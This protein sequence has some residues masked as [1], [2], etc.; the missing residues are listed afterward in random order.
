MRKTLLLTAAAFAVA[1][2]PAAAR[3]GSGY[4]GIEGGLLFPKDQDAD[5]DVDFTTTQTPATPAGP[6]GP[7]D[8]NFE[9]SFGLDYKRGLDIDA[10]AGFDFGAFR[11]E[12]ELGY[13]RSKLDEFEFDDGDIAAIN[14]ALN[15]PSGTGDPGAPGLPAISDT[16]FDLG[17]RV[18]VL[19]G[20][21]NALADFGDENGVSFYAGGG[22]GRA[23]VKAFGD[24]DAAWAFQAIA[25][26]RYAISPGIDFGLKYRYFR[27]GNVN[28]TDDSFALAGNPNAVT[29]ATGAGPVIVNQTSN[30]VAFADFENK[31]RSHSLLASLIFNFGAPEA[32]LPPP[33]PPP[34]PMVEQAP[35]TQTCPDGSVILATSSCP[36]PPPPPP[37]PPVERGE[38]GQ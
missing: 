35:A 19:S 25:G 12:G 20:M 32:P 7:A 14:T 8:T 15:R 27:T 11:I 1:A 29:V 5:L 18:S 26:V 17:G 4:F 33:P 3:D 2:T 6:A 37:P 24:R 36:L 16:S 22:V 38:R 23:R 31:F 34:P 28:L 30:A 13:K 9:N 10:I 21:V